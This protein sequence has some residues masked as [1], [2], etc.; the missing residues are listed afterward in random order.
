M[1][2]QRLRPCVWS[3]LVILAINIPVNAKDKPAGDGQDQTR[4]K[5]ADPKVLKG[6]LTRLLEVYEA[7]GM[8]DVKGK[9]W[10]TVDAGPKKDAVQLTGW[11]VAETPSELTVLELDGGRET[12]RKP[13]SGEQRPEKNI[14]DG[15]NTI[16][17]DEYVAA[18]RKNRVVWAVEKGDY[19]TFVTKFLD[20]GVPD[21]DR[22]KDR[23]ED[24]YTFVLDRYELSGHVDVAC[25]YGCWAHLQGD[26]ELA[27][28]LLAQAEE[29]RVKYVGRYI[30]DEE[31]TKSLAL[32]VANHIAKSRRIA[33][34]SGSHSRTPRP[35]LLK[36][37]QQLAKIPL[38]SYKTDAEEMIKSYESLIAED[39][40]WKEP[41]EKTLAKMTV[42]E[43]VAYW[44][45]HLRDAD[46]GQWS[47]PGQ[48]SVFGDPF[49]GFTLGN[50]EKSKKP[51][52]AVELKNLGLDAVPE[53]IAHLDDARPTR[54]QGHWRSYWPDSFYPLRYGDAC[55]QIF[56]AIT[57]QTIYGRRT[58]NGYPIA[59]GK[60]KECKEK[61]EKWLADFTKK[62]EKQWLIDAT[63]LGDGDSSRQ[64]ARLIKKYPDAAYGAVTKGIKNAS[65]KSVRSN[66]V[67]CLCEV[68]DDRVAGFLLE[69]L[70][71]PDLSGRLSAARGLTDRGKAQGFQALLAEWKDLK[72]DDYDSLDVTDRWAVE[73]LVRDLIWS[74]KVE[75]V[76]T[77]RTKLRTRPIFLRW[78][79]LEAAGNVGTD[80]KEKV[81]KEF[82][83]AIDRL[84][85]E[86][87]SDTEE[88]EYRSIRWGEKSI[89]GRAVGD[90][91]AVFL[92]R[93]LQRPDEFDPTADFRTRRRQRI[94]LA[95]IWR[96]QVGLDQL[97]LPPSLKIEPAPDAKTA[98][99]TAAV[100]SD[101]GRAK[102]LADLEA[103]GLPAL[104][105]VNTLFASL[106]KDH[107]ARTD[108][109]HLAARLRTRV[110]EVAFAPDS[111][112]P[113]PEIR[114][115]V[116][117][118]RG[119]RIVPAE[120]QEDL[121]GMLDQL[122]DDAYGVEIAVE[123]PGDETGT[124]V[125]LT[126]FAKRS[127]SFRGPGKHWQ[128]H[129]RVVLDGKV[130]CNRIFGAEEQIQADNM[131][132]FSAALQK[133]LDAVP[134]QSISARLGLAIDQK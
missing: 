131:T 54:C 57:G 61:A 70:K 45:Y 21:P 78:Q 8:T 81:A 124:T 9:K 130:I 7:I 58:T 53:I 107:P 126:L 90:L 68:Q 127:L 60:G 73:Q 41:D 105:A 38:H 118:W 64:A 100:K 82:S 55:Q 2:V 113:T 5:A 119:R 28:K 32:F 91:A 121:R 76:N 95:N 47:D 71:G 35:E 36:Q 14:T 79:V 96:K 66:L 128:T 59:D 42:K 101:T 22:K 132:Q 92:A 27:I 98:P 67:S 83:E 80:P 16:P 84:L 120:L 44:M 114:R 33:A 122:P 69:E 52:P 40:A 72:T 62:G 108:V 19:K 17:L 116:E 46:A 20:A 99:L 15:R 93:R 24:V 30:G 48:C 29:A 25:R 74:G 10:V 13:K 87:L 11:L 129:E 102:A 12:I 51:N 49:G 110:Q 103:L 50:G 106:P 37:W 85:A 75:A 31:T 39:N 86:S 43:K 4:A 18:A 123:H 56:E 3:V 34:I 111:L 6:E 112:T 125:V 117:G 63:A 1:S 26:D 97:P 94:T 134:N 65:E 23:R 77:L 104:P 115:K 88:T 89:D 109:Q 133:A